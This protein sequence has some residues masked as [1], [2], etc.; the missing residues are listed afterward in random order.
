MNCI[1]TTFAPSETKEGLNAG[2]RTPFTRAAHSSFLSGRM[3][4]GKTTLKGDWENNIL[5][6][7]ASYFHL[8]DFFCGIDLIASQIFLTT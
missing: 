6:G 1:K 4:K 2:K 3:R 8:E 5:T 7:L